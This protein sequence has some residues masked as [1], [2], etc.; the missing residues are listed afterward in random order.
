MSCDDAE[1]LA[2][3]LECMDIDNPRSPK[4]YIA[5]MSEWTVEELRAYFEKRRREMEGP[6]GRFRP[7]P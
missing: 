1:K 7:H 3:V 2:V 5:N 6:K 4:E